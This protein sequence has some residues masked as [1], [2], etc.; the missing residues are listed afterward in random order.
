M[1]TDRLTG[2]CITRALVRCYNIQSLSLPCKASCGHVKEKPHYSHILCTTCQCPLLSLKVTHSTVVQYNKKAPRSKKF[3]CIAAIVV[4]V[5]RTATSYKLLCSCAN[6]LNATCAQNNNNSRYIQCPVIEWVT[7]R[8]LACRAEDV[9]SSWEQCGCS[10]SSTCPHEAMLG[11]TSFQWK[12]SSFRAFCCS[13]D[14][15]SGYA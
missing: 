10:F 3:T 9:I 6:V 1:S 4:V 13:T 8:A 11:E 7:L 15:C 5:F 12:I 2:L 14:Q